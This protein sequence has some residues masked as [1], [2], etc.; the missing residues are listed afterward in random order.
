MANCQAV[1]LTYNKEASKWVPSG[2]GNGVSRVQLY[3]HTINNTFRV[4][5]RNVENREVNVNSAFTKSTTYHL[6]TPT[7]HQW[8]DPRHVYGLNFSNADEAG[9]FADAAT[10]AVKLLKEAAGAP[11]PVPAKEAP[12]PATKAAE[13]PRAQPA[14]GPLD[15]HAATQAKELANALARRTTTMDQASA[16]RPPPREPSPEPDASSGAMYETASSALAG[17]SEWKKHNEQLETGSG[18]GSFKETDPY[19][20]R[21]APSGGAPPA[22]PIPPAPGPPPVPPPDF[23]NSQAS[24]LTERPS[25]VDAI[26]SAKL[27]P[28]SARK[29][30]PPAAAKPAS[31]LSMQEEM[32]AKLQRRAE[33][34]KADEEPKKKAPPPVANK[35]GSATAAK[36]S[37]AASKAS[38]VDFDALKQAI[39]GEAQAQIETFSKALLAGLADKIEGLRP[40]DLT[41]C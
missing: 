39:L 15:G 19:P 17:V 18:G 7:F 8:R 29:I 25:L 2:P 41:D 34:S 37:G 32:A 3:K 14:A 20:A 38:G 16:T 4:V 30:P 21:G 13:P 28:G 23:N 5:G 31:G 26:A 24:T 9:S 22:P 1:V 33:M 35:R 12:K 11:A 36:L 6:A 10:S 40:S 27:T